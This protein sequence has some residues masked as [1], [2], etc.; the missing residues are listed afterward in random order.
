MNLSCYKCG[1]NN[2]T[3]TKIGFRE[4]CFSCGEDLHCCKNCRF[5]DPS[6]YNECHETQ[7]D[8]VVEK[9]RANFCDY[10]QQGEGKAA[11]FNP[12]DEARRKLEDLFK[13]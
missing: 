9:T 11:T 1:K 13:K 7:A 12:A 6:C 10:F 3:E 4:T 5:Y 8:R 2:P